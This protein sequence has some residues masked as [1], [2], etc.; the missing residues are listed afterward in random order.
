MCTVLIIHVQKSTSEILV[1]MY[2]QG[3]R[4]ATLVL[5]IGKAVRQILPGTR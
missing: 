2:F 3:H 1:T 4:F 5:G